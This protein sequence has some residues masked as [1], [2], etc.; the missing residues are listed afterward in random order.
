MITIDKLHAVKTVITH[1][2]C[3]DGL[4]SAMLLKDALEPGVSFRFLHHETV[5]HRTLAA[6]PGM[7]YADFSPPAARA[8]EFVD[9]GAL[10]LDHHK[11]ARRVVEAFG[12]NGVFGDE[13]TEPG[14]CGATLVHKHVWGPLVR[15]FRPKS[16][17]S[18]PT[19][20]DGFASHFAALAGIRDTWQRSDPRWREACIQHHVLMFIP[21]E[22]WMGVSLTS[23]AGD[24]TRSL[25][26]LGEI[27]QEKQDEATR[28]VIAGAYR[29]T[30]SRGTRVVVFEGLRQT[31]DAAEA[32]GADA[33]L[34][35]GFGF[36]VER[37]GDTQK[38]KM[39]LSTRSHTTFDCA[40]MAKAHGGGGHTKAAG[41]SRALDDEREHP[42]ELVRQ[43]VEKWESRVVAGEARVSK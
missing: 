19:S 37:A 24:W 40:A 31:S 4:V 22:R 6:E 34:V 39:M 17:R 30:T 10:V 28:D 25:A 11:T 3:A 7:L 21:R 26:E 23:I 8:Q 2:D 43:L 33:D 18:L 35:V 14:V 9:A 20:E 12:E 42:Y 27:L 1:A 32:L 36:R 38:P 16:G 5:E 29:F 13:A 41:F 15:P